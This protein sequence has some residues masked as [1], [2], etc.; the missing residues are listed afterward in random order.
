MSNGENHH[1]ALSIL[2][3]KLEPFNIKM[4]PR[5]KWF[6]QEQFADIKP[7]RWTDKSDAWNKKGLLSNSVVCKF[8]QQT[9]LQSETLSAFFNY[10][11][12]YFCHW[13]RSF[14]NFLSISEKARWWSGETLSIW[15]K[16]HNIQSTRSSRNERNITSTVDTRNIAH[17]FVFL[18]TW[19][20]YFGIPEY[21]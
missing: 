14:E 20:F 1:E 2:I 16:P 19:L 7:I 11:M 21:W 6:N 18:R 13:I 3:S 9:W 8:R 5:S 12:S 10:F 4:I 15:R 17:L